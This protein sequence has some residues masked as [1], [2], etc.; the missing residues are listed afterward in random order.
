MFIGGCANK[1]EQIAATHVVTYKGLP[2]MPEG[3]EDILVKA[4]TESDVPWGE[5]NIQDIRES[6]AAIN[7]MGKFMQIKSELSGT[8]PYY[9]YVASFEYLRA[10]YLRLQRSLDE[11]VAVP[12]AVTEQA[13]LLYEMV[14]QRIF[15]GLSTQQDLI[16]MENG[17]INGMAS[18]DAMEQLK[19]V[20]KLVKPLL[21]A[22]I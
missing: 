21:G 20:Y 8:V 4:F 1:V 11:R 3:A 15:A 13:A 12:G 2:P 18:Q 6:R 19:D 10:Q 22:V 5:E 16:T 17:K 14:K 7:S 9:S